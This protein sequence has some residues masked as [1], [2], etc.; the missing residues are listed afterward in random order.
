MTGASLPKVEQSFYPMTGGLDLMTPP[1]SVSPGKCF[2]AQNYEPEISGGYRRIDGFERYDGRPSPTAA[3]YTV[4]PIALTGTIANGATVTGLTSG[5]TGRA[6]GIYNAVLVLGRTVGIFAK[7][8]AIQVAA[9]TQAT[10]T[11]TSILSGATSPSDDADYKLLAANDVRLDIQT[12]PGSGSMRGV[13]VYKDKVYAF[14]DNAGG[15]AGAMWLATAGGWASVAFGTELAYTSATGGATSINVGDTIQNAASAP[16]KTA[17]VKAVLLRT[18]SWGT[19]AVGTLVITP[20]T[21][22]FASADPIFVGATQKAAASA[23]AATITR[24]PGGTLEFENMNFTGSTLTQ[25]MYGSDGVNPC[26]EFDGTTYVPIHTGMLNDTPLHLRFHRNFLFLSF[27]GS[28][29]FSALGNPYTWTAILGAGELTTGDAITGFLP[30]GGNVQGSSLAIF[31]KGKTSILYGSSA[32]DFRLVMSI[33]DLGYSDYTIQPVS[34]TTYGLTARGVQGL[35]TTLTYGDFDFASITHEVQTLITSKRG[36]E[37]SSN[38]SRTKDQYRVYWSD[39]TGLAI[40]LTGDQISGVMPLN[41]GKPVRCITTAILSNGAEATYFGSDDGYVYQD[42]T[43]TSFDGL[44]IESWI[45]PVFNHLK[46]PRVR[47]RYR[48]ATF[49]VKATGYAQVNI[50]ADLGYA[51]PDVLPAAPRADSVLVGAGGYWDQFT[52]DQF[53]WETTSEAS[54]SISVEGTEKNISFMFY[55]N[56]AQDRSHT[57]QGV[58]LSYSIRRNER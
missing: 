33:F 42:N 54:P 37:I 28:A 2:D 51:T 20:V 23:S 40:G 39:G 24:L 7:G 50:T 15:T 47:K 57:V 36:L 26:F 3:P 17:I 10:T 48:R 29:Q 18:G 11:S 25:K 44:A 41:Y 4:L 31:T 32:V 16:T 6:L 45:R 43:G 9:V 53:T 19:S 21:G 5:A 52:W 49:E 58:S 35:I 55:S 27:L 34:N 46:S 38:S 1:I 12:V 56:R 22:S 14:R 8:E 13:W 30:Q